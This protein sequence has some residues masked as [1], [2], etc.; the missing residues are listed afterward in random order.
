[1]FTNIN[2]NIILGRKNKINHPIN[3]NTN[4]NT[5]IENQNLINTPTIINKPTPIEY[6]V[7][8]NEFPSELDTTFNSDSKTEST[9]SSEYVE[10]EKKYWEYGNRGIKI[11]NFKSKMSRNLAIMYYVDRVFVE[12]IDKSLSNNYNLLFNK[13]NS[14]IFTLSSGIINSVKGEVMVRPIH[15]DNKISG[16]FNILDAAYIK[17]SNINI[18]EKDLLKNNIPNIDSVLNHTNNLFHIIKIISI[19]KLTNSFK[20]KENIS[21]DT[22]S[23]KTICTEA[24]EYIEQLNLNNNKKSILKSDKNSGFYI[25]VYNDRAKAFI[26]DGKNNKIHYVASTSHFNERCVSI[27]YYTFNL[28]N[29]K[30]K[31]I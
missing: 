2:K 25:K 8:D 30:I 3:Q 9:E 29:G 1:M 24:F 11:N 20:L 19:L 28:V 10:D 7:R 14:T 21:E 5:N 26:I 18:T 27:R 4:T 15:P 31:K 6:S 22:L 16:E 17:I 12:W 13:E 23:F